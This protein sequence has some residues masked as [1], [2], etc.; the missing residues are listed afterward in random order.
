[1]FFA[2]YIRRLLAGENTSPPIFQFLIGGKL[3]H[4][5]GSVFVFLSAEGPSHLPLTIAIS[6]SCATDFSVGD[7][8]Q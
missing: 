7:I 4:W 3:K 8:V 5:R 1:V 2:A 6:D